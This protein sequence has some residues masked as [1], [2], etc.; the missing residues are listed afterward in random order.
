ME[1]FTVS[2]DDQLFAQFDKIVQDRGYDNRSEAVRDLV[3]GYLETVRLQKD[4]KGYCIA[5][6]SYIYNHHERDLASQVTSIHHHHHNLTLSSMHVH[7]D[8]DNCLEVVILRG[9]IQDVR[10]FA[11]QVMATNGVR[12]GKLH[13]VPVEFSQEQHA[14]SSVSHEH[15][16]PH[17]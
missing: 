9:T 8:H 1:R 6:L 10:L 3:R 16:S 11:N 13:V 2:M 7:M 17:T 12:H 5:T 4:N 14:H 15:S